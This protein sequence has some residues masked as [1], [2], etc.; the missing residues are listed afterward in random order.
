MNLKNRMLQKLEGWRMRLLSYAERLT[1]IKT[2]AAAMPVYM[3]S[4]NKI[5]LSTCREL[6]ALVWRYWWIGN[7]NKDRFMAMRSN[8]EMAFQSYSTYSG[9]DDLVDIFSD[10][11]KNR[12]EEA[13]WQRILDGKRVICTD[14]SWLRG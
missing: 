5:P 12:L 4:T 6:D 11:P 2:V 3:M 7:S 10:P 9:K 8:I 1:L 14:A 13:D